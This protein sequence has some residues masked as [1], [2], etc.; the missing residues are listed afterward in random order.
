MCIGEAMAAGLPVISTTAAAIT[1]MVEH[2]VTGL[3]V[4]PGNVLQLSGALCRVIANP[5]LRA[6]IGNAG[7]TKALRFYTPRVV[8]E[9]TLT[10]YEK[11]NK[12]I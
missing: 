1:E 9:K 7:R 5:I 12:G 3:V 2:E 6:A 8:A 4:E 11:I 10:L